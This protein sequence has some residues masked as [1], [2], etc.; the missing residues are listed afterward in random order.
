M[1]HPLVAVDADGVLLNYE[2]HYRHLAEVAL[3]RSFDREIDP[4]ADHAAERYGIPR[5]PETWAKLAPLFA[6]GGWRTLPALPGAVEAARLLQEQDVRLVC[7]SCL[8]E[9]FAIDRAENLMALG[10]H[11]DDVI[12]V[13]AGAAGENP[14]RAVLESLAPDVFVDDW[15]SNFEGLPTRTT[16]VWVTDGQRRRHDRCLKSLALAHHWMPSFHDFARQFLADPGRFV[17]GSG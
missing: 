3:G 4:E 15:A 2:H 13:G 1:G 7:V 11:V 9:E 8:P 14:K 12:A 10:I 17:L 6:Q 16:C 5:N